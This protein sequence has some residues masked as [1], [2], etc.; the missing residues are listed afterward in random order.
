MRIPAKRAMRTKQLNRPFPRLSRITFQTAR[1]FALFEL[2]RGARLLHLNPQFILVSPVCMYPSK[3]AGTKP[4]VPRRERFLGGSGS[5][6]PV[7]EKMELGAAS[8]RLNLFSRTSGARNRYGRR[9][10]WPLVALPRYIGTVLLTKTRAS[11]QP[12][13]Q[14]ATWI[15]RIISATT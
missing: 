12:M 15:S 8:L 4:V 11:S 5:H 14:P 7:C 10:Y 9:A 13:I 3:I 6:C 2:I 1:K